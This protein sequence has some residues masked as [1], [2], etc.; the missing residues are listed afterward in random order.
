MTRIVAVIPGRMGSTRFPGKMLADDTG[1]PLIIHSALNAR[2]AARI[3]EVV[4]AS[5]SDAIAAAA[6]AAGFTHVMTRADHPN[7]TS[8]IAE[9][10]DTIEADLIVNV[11]GDEPDLPPAAID[12]AIE[13]LLADPDASVGTAAARL[14][15]TDDVHN[16]AV[17]KVVI[18]ARGGALYFSRAAIPHDRDGLDAQGCSPLRHVG[19]YVYSPAAL[20]DYISLPEGTLERLECLEQLRLLEH[21]R[22]IAVATVDAPHCGIDTPEQYAAW[23]AQRATAKTNA[24]DP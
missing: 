11:Q 19:L 13:A 4:I 14:N 6:H 22:R 21:G 24:A 1:T 9:A 3:D 16:P 2:A 17:V 5:D 15:D 23:V 20:R 8:R 7:G 10:I 12:A 18:D